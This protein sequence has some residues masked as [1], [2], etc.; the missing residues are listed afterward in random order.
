MSNQKKAKENAQRNAAAT[1]AQNLSN[2]D[3]NKQNSQSGNNRI[4][5]INDGYNSGYTSP[6]P[7]QTPTSPTPPQFVDS[8]VQRSQPTNRIFAKNQK[9]FSLTQMPAQSPPPSSNNPTFPKTF[10]LTDVKQNQNGQQKKLTPVSEKY[11]YHTHDEEEDDDE[12][13]DSDEGHDN[14]GFYLNEAATKTSNRPA[15]RT[16]PQA[17]KQ[18]GFVHHAND[19]EDMTTF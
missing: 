9:N 1:F 11:T 16:P 2:D 8:D 19:E 3:Y 6:P 4:M 17:T 10:T 5:V 15:A 7:P 13:Y 18:N 14:G 12:E